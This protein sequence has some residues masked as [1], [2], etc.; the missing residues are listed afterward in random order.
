MR[1]GDYIK[2]RRN[3]LKLG[4]RETCRLT[5]DPFVPSPIQS[6][7]YLSRLENGVD[8]EMRADAASIDKLWGLGRALRTSPLE[9]FLLSRDRCDLLY[10]IELFPLRTALSQNFGEFM[11]S[12]RK[13]LN[14]SVREASATNNLPWEI[15]SGYWSQIETNFRECTAK[16]SGEKLWS[17]GLVLEVDP[18]LLYALSRKMDPKVL[19]AEAR[20]N[21]FK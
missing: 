8:T 15:S 21:L 1:F 14:L 5:K 11:K 13:Q 19:S 3:E 16:I 7:I 2:Q 9:L 10:Q 6:P 18:L 20:D 17:I 12:K 4:L